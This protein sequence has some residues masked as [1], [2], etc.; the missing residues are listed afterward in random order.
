MSDHDGPVLEVAQHGA[1]RWLHLS[2]PHHRNALNRPLVAALQDQITS[3]EQADGT[4]VVVVTG[5]GAGF[6]AGADLREL[7]ALHDAGTHPV[8]FLREVSACFSRIEAS[9]VAWVAA[10]HGHAVAGGLELA[11]AC[12]VVLAAEGTLIGDGHLKHS[13]LP[14]GGSSVR[15]PRAVGRSTARWLML[16]GELVPAEQL[17]ATGWLHAIVPEHQLHA[18]AEQ[19]AATL[20]ARPAGAFGRFKQLLARQEAAASSAALAAELDAFAENWD[21]GH[22]A[23]ALRRF[24]R[25]RAASG[26]SS[27]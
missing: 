13:L 18:A 14:A 19:A 26:R 3:A 16:T 6:C 4:R 21:H 25:P 17:Q 23:D 22:A 20:A 8:E 5:R 1:V 2:R 9:P 11:L 10:L 15:L 24:V 12:D 7:L 27:R